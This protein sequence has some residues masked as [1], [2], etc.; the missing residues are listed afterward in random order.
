MPRPSAHTEVSGDHLQKQ[1]VDCFSILNFRILYFC[2][3]HKKLVHELIL[4]LLRE[5]SQTMLTSV[6]LTTYPPSLT[7][8]TLYTL[9]KSQHFWTTYPTLG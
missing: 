6:F 4:L 2:L 7:F 5:R 1:N 3:C 8:S 9:K